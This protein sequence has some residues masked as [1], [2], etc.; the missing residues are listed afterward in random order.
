MITYNITNWQDFRDLSGRDYKYSD[1]AWEVL[2]D[3]FDEASDD[4]DI[5]LTWELFNHIEEYDSA[6]QVMRTFHEEAYHDFICE[7]QNEKYA[8]ADHD[9][10]DP[11]DCLPD[12]DELE[13][14]ALEFVKSK[15]AEVWELP[16]FGGLLIDHSSKNYDY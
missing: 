2:F 4:C 11:D 5:E 6:V 1:E 14:Y 7:L 15:Y 3:S 13:P 9:L 8:E 16:V 12:E 10:T